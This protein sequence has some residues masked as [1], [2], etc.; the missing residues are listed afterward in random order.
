MCADQELVVCVL[1]ETYRAVLRNVSASGVAVQVFGS[2]A[3]EGQISMQFG[4]RRDDV[5]E[6]FKSV[7][8]IETHLDTVWA[9]VYESFQ[10][11]LIVVVGVGIAFWSEDV[12]QVIVDLHVFVVGHFDGVRL[13]E[14]AYCE[15][16][17]FVEWFGLRCF[18]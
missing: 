11:S 3:K 8:A 1:F 17:H 13:E 14:A 5:S 4:V 15:G 7:G 12:F 10:D 6:A 18:K 9:I 2:A 16:F